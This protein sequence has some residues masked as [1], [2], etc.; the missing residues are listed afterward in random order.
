MVVSSRLT[1][2]SRDSFNTNVQ[3]FAAICHGR[4]ILAF[5]RRIAAASQ[6]FAASRRRDP[7]DLNSLL[8]AAAADPR[9]FLSKNFRCTACTKLLCLQLCC[10]EQCT[11]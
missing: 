5:F 1:P 9:R 3:K 4:R 11:R 2:A 6:T 10:F 8:D 7:T